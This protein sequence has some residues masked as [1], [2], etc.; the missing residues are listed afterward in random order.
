MTKLVERV[1]NKWEPLEEWFAARP[2]KPGHAQTSQFSLA[3]KREPLS[4]MLL[5]L[6]P[7]S[8]LNV[9]S[10]AEAPTQVQT[11]LTL[12]K[13]HMV[14]L[15]PREPLRVHRSTAQ[16]ERL[17]VPTDLAPLVVQARRMLSE[18]LDQR[19]FKRYTDL[20]NT[21]EAS[22]AFEVQLLLQP[23]FKNLDSP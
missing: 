1:L 7:I 23:Q 9:M 17:F 15:S 18:A 14:T 3:G 4:Q 5:L 13:L 8:A 12:Y 2:R 6:R 10:Q 22:F 20:G 16:N 11:L 21:V 19:F